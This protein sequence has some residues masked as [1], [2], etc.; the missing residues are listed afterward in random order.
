MSCIS[1]LSPRREHELL[2]PV[3]IN[4]NQ[5]V[6][7]DIESRP[8]TPRASLSTPFQSNTNDISHDVNEDSM[9]ISD[10]LSEGEI[11]SGD[12]VVDSYDLPATP[13]ISVDL[14]RSGQNK[15]CDERPID[16]VHKDRDNDISSDHID[17][18]SKEKSSEPKETNQSQVLIIF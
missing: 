12:E 3:T 6:T 4:A 8:A 16:S 1:E 13:N 11:L 18:P 14:S 7:K 10:I 15:D 5:S 2:N 17:R 9:D